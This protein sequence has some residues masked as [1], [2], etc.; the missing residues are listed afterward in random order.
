M[1]WIIG[2]S[3][4]WSSKNLCDQTLNAQTKLHY[5]VSNILFFAQQCQ[6]SGVSAFGATLM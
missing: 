1:R 3:S 4:S 2:S 5:T 6:H